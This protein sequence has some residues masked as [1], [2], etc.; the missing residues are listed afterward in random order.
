MRH[1]DFIVVGAGTAGC[2]VVA[3]H[4]SGDPTATVLVVEAGAE[5]T[6]LNPTHSAPVAT[7]EIMLVRPDAHLG[8]RG[9]GDPDGLD[10]WLIAVAGQDPAG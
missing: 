8:W 10:R 5:D 4:L 9:P 6:W 1:F 7:R 2:C 3:H